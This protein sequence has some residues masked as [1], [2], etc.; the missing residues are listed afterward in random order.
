MDT[1]G[2]IVHISPGFKV[3]DASKCKPVKIEMEDYEDCVDHAERLGLDACNLSFKQGDIHKK[4]S[5]TNSFFSMKIKKNGKRSN[6]NIL[7]IPYRVRDR[8]HAL[9]RATIQIKSIKGNIYN[10]GLRKGIYIS[11]FANGDWTKFITDHGLCAGDELFFCFKENEPHLVLGFKAKRDRYKTSK[12]Y[13]M[14]ESVRPSFSHAP[15]NQYPG[16]D[17]VVV[18]QNAR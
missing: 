6:H 8:V 5:R 18:V 10:V 17:A 2:D 9:G 14:V 4:K 1:Q 12:G 3:S 11:T 7:V 15:F 16:Q 13:T